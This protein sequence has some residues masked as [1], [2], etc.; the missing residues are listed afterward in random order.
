MPVSMHDVR[1]LW[2]QCK[3]KLLN[4]L[5]KRIIA[6]VAE[7]GSSTFRQINYN[8]YTVKSVGTKNGRVKLCFYILQI[9][10]STMV[11]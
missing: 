8:M 6:V 3:I 5:M 7:K 11:S 4:N 2:E 9:A 10:N 1:V